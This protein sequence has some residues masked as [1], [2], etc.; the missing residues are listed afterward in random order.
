MVEP[1]RG[2]RGRLGV[3]ARGLVGHRAAQHHPRVVRDPRRGAE[4]PEVRFHVGGEC[5]AMLG[6]ARQQL[7]HDPSQPFGGVVPGAFPRPQRIP[8]RLGHHDGHGGAFEGH[9]PGDQPVEQHA[10]GVQVDAGAVQRLAHRLLGGHEVRGAQHDLAVGQ[11]G[12]RIAA[13]GGGD[14]EVCDLDREHAV[15]LPGDEEVLRLD[16]AVQDLARVHV[17]ERVKYLPDQAGRDGR[18]QVGVEHVRHRQALE[19]LHGQVVV[20]PLLAPAAEVEDAHDIGV[21]DAG[22]QAGLAQEAGPGARVVEVGMQDLDRDDL[23][24]AE[25]LRAVDSA[26]AATAEQLHHAVAPVDLLADQLPDGVH[27]SSALLEA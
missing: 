13:D 4:G 25:A 24:G 19:Q 1:R 21:L 8:P 10:Q 7:E 23:L 12:R 16:V 17:R 11:A 2:G 20:V 3:R 6:L 27:S 5:V 14:A 22:R 18:G 9:A 15:G 26:H